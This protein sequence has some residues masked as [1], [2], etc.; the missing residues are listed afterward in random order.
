MKEDITFIGNMGLYI[1]D[2]NVIQFQMGDSFQPESMLAV[3]AM[4]RSGL[5]QSWY[6]V[7]GYQI[8]AR[9]EADNEC[10]EIERD[11]KQNRL[12][13]QLLRK[14][15]DILY[16]QGL[17]VYKREL[18]DGKY[19]RVYQDSPVIQEWLDS[20][21][22]NGLECGYRDVA[23]SIIKNYYYFSDFFIKW[24]M[25]KGHALGRTSIHV[26]GLEVME[27]R[28]CR[29]ATRRTDTPFSVI[30]YKDMTHVAVARFGYGNS[31][32]Q[33]YPRFT[34]AT[35][36]DFLYAGISHHRDKSIGR[37]YGSNETFEGSRNYI[38]GSNSTAQYI[39]SFLKNSLAAKI[40]IIIPDAWVEAKR[41]Q[42]K[43]ICDEN[44][45]RAAKTPAE[46][47]L[48]YNGIK[49]G[50]EYLESTLIEYMRSEL[51]KVGAY[52]SGAENQG[53]AYASI[54]F[55]PTGSNAPEEWKFENI[56]LKYKE[57]VD[58][59]IAYDRRADEALL[60]AVGMDSSISSVSK[61]GVI[62][63]SG[64]DVFY[65]YLIYL[66]G[67]NPHDEIC[68]EP[69]NWALSINFPE[70]YKEGLRLGFYRETPSRQEEISPK[71]RLQ[72]QQS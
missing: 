22:A 13:P 49:V 43:S 10:D 56:D 66:M 33:I 44:R 9:G 28:N 3:P 6:G 37:I 2:G 38:K 26:A 29:L 25:T 34:P 46:P 27:N 40:H 31:Q 15:R 70:L 47:T 16:G 32:Y 61:E 36:G 72:N 7:K 54:S 30:P 45:R 57:Y 55:R 41:K 19:V 59:L 21:E 52:L 17:A 23:K 62:S 69:F 58:A 42:I 20:W 11:I 63:K 24:R 1:N 60:S 53:K 64:S 68:A 50:T 14:Q 71:D 5:E 8:L 48:L 18:K 51:R 12:L 4:F 67:L 35:A 65:N 39:N